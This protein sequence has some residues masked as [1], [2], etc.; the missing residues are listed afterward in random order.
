ML[1]IGC[2][3][4]DVFLHSSFFLLHSLPPPGV[5]LTIAPPASLPPPRVAAAARQRSENRQGQDR[6]HRRQ[7]HRSLQATGPKLLQRC[8]V[9]T[10]RELRLTNPNAV[11]APQLAHFQILR[12]RRR[13]RAEF[14]D[15]K[16]ILP[17]HLCGN[18]APPC[19]TRPGANSTPIRH[20]ACGVLIGHIL[21][22]RSPSIN[23]RMLHQK[24][25]LPKTSNAA[26]RTECISFSMFSMFSVFGG[27][28]SRF[29]LQASP[30][31]V[32]CLPARSPTKAGSLLAVQPPS[33]PSFAPS[34]LI[35]SEVGR[36]RHLALAARLGQSRQP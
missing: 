2:W 24:T 7:A 25:L 36:S 35:P 20:P 14:A 31:D 12:K 33:L 32:G 4:L 10:G 3:M 17:F 9:A 16:P 8:R 26:Q 6:Q 22:W 30:L 5:R 1:D 13:H 21:A 19:R 23:A 11:D 29:E 28:C 18:R 34:L 27:L 15:R